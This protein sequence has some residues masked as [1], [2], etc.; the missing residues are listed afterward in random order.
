MGW[1][2]NIMHLCLPTST[3]GTAI[4]LSLTRNSNGKHYRR[5]HPELII[6]KY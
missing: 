1:F 4:S 6:S 2:A 3:F 5:I